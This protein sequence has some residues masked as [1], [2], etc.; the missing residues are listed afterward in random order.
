MQLKRYFFGVVLSACTFFVLFAIKFDS[1]VIESYGKQLENENT[2]DVKSENL[3]RN[4][5]RDINE[6]IRELTKCND[7]Q[8]ESKIGQRSNFWVRI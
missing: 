4:N 1:K 5:A 2:E 6:E 3:I 8:L 7:K